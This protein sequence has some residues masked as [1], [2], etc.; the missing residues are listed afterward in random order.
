MAQQVI[1]D[2]VTWSGGLVQLAWFK[3]PINW[4][5]PSFSSVMMT[6][7]LLTET[8]NGLIIPENHEIKTRG[9]LQSGNKSHFVRL[10]WPMETRVCFSEEKALTL[11]L[12]VF[13]PARPRVCARFNNRL[14]SRPL[15][16]TAQGGRGHD[17]P[18]LS[19]YNWLLGHR[20]SPLWWG[21]SLSWCGIMRDTDGGH[22]GT[23]GSWISGFPSEETGE[24]R[25]SKHCG[26]ATSYPPK[27]WT[28]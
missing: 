16:Q 23:V 13:W 17:D 25:C 9:G 24:W 26:G 7:L 4:T 15:P 10:K 6:S 2:L 8:I 11:R 5:E 18:I 28:T 22:L 3:P 27:P 1:I 14:R 20:R 12:E 19:C 21:G